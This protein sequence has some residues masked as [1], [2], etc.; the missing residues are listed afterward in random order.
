MRLPQVE[1][2]TRW[3]SGDGRSVAIVALAPGE[4]EKRAGVTFIPGE[5]DLNEFCYAAI[6]SPS[7]GQFWL[8]RYEGTPSD[9]TEVLVDSDLDVAR[10]LA[11]VTAALSGVVELGRTAPE[12]PHHRV[13]RR[14][15]A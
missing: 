10:A 5:D 8:W 6:G 4:I 12:A 11:A 14:F 3:P 2:W 1:P 13:R 9:E 15:P 7:I